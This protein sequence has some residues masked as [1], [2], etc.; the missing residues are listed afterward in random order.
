M[1]DP[2]A[3]RSGRLGQGRDVGGTA[4]D[5]VERR[6]LR[7][8]RA[9]HVLDTP[10][11]DVFD[12]AVALAAEVCGTPV[13]LLSL[14]DE[15][16]QWFKAAHGTELR[17]TAREI[18]FCQ[19]AVE[20]REPLVVTDTHE[21]HRFRDNPLVTGSPHLRAYAGIPLVLDDGSAVGTVCVLDTEPH[22][23]TEAQLTSLGR[24]ASQVREILELRRRSGV[25]QEQASWS[26]SVGVVSAPGRGGRRR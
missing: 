22:H 24:V 9:C 23:F 20:E 21:D 15:R 1:Q 17:E 11:E 13:A 5:E 10:A 7:A 16:R 25:E 3:P 18:A 2:H 26:E 19:L 14:L 4:P 12:D 6:R 8:L